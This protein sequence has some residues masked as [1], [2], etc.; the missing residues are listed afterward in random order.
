MIEFLQRWSLV[1]VAIGISLSRQGSENG[2]PW[3]TGLG[4]AVLIGGGIFF[5]FRRIHNLGWLIAI[6]GISLLLLGAA[7]NSIFLGQPVDTP[8]TS[9]IIWGIVIALSGVGFWAYSKFS[10]RREP[11]P[12]E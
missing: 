3:L 12:V 6:A 9:L 1:I 5:V 8:N 2:S 10:A 7:K 11:T 4:V